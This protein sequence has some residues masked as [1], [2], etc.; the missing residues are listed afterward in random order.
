MVHKQ[1]KISIY[2]HNNKLMN[3]QECLNRTLKLENF[4][5]NSYSLLIHINYSKY[6]M[7]TCTM[8]FQNTRIAHLYLRD[9]ISSLIESNILT[10]I[11]IK[12]NDNLNSQIYHVSLSIYRIQFDENIFN[13]AIFKQTKCIDIQ[14]ILK[15][16][17]DDLFKSFNELNLIRIHTEHVKQLFAINNKW[18]AYL[19]YNLKSS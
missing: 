5:S 8:A 6:S 9:I 17:Q 10:F 14:G 3:E 18:L 13:Q 2:I 11:Q 7:K 15:G 19:N 4:I 12:Q 16:I 1:I